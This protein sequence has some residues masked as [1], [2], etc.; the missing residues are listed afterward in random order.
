MS[1]VFF[2][3]MIFFIHDS[4]DNILCLIHDCAERVSQGADDLPALLFICTEQLEYPSDEQI[5]ETVFQ[6]FLIRI[7]RCMFKSADDGCHFF[8]VILNALISIVGDPVC[9]FL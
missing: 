1:C 9:R 2:I 3:M 8:P 4:R 7:F 6:F 5:A